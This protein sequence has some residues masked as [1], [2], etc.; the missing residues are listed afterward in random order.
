MGIFF[1]RKEK[2]SNSIEWLSKNSIQLREPAKCMPE[3]FEFLRHIVKDKRIVWLGENGHNIREHNMMKSKII[4]FLHK[5]MNFTV[6]AF[7]SGLAECYSANELKKEFTDEDFLK[8]AIY[9][10][11]ATKEN[12]S[13]FQLMKKSDLSLI[14]IDSNP[15]SN[16]ELFVKFVQQLSSVVSEDVIEKI[17]Y[18][19]AGAYKW[20]YQLGQYKARRKKVP[21]EML[22]EFATFKEKASAVIADLEAIHKEYIFDLENQELVR[23]FK[24]ILRCL[25]NRL[26]FINHFHNSYRTYRK[27][28]EKRM[29]EN[30][31]W[32][33]QELYPDEKIII[34]AHNLHI[35]K[36]YKT[37]TGFEPLGA[38]VS[39]EI[40]EQSYYLGLFMYEG[41]IHTDTGQP[42]KIEKP[43]KKSLEDYMHQV[44]SPALFTDF[45]QLEKTSVNKWIFTKTIFLEGGTMPTLFVP[46]DQLDGALLVESVSPP[47]YLKRNKKK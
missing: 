32:V 38:I 6:L 19:E 45:S 42:Y 22:R 24:I 47:E 25:Q 28:R 36:Q 44:Q 20:Y 35:F 9:S 7:E 23:Q 30:L 13:L 40:K 34:W 33:C 27:G 18:I 4:E 43:P 39:S 37:F 15:S 3:E 41:E 2:Y 5:E 26:Y 16:P 29:K 8:N 17:E 12:L 10:L 14:G 46:R 1:R 21:A 31:E 11:W